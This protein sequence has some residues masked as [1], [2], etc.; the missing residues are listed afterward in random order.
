MSIILPDNKYKIILQGMHLVNISYIYFDK[1]RGRGLA[2]PCRFAPVQTLV[3]VSSNHIILP[4]NKYKI[5]LQGMHLV[6]LFYTRNWRTE[7]DS[8]PR[9]ENANSLAGCRLNHS[10][11]YPLNYNSTLDYFYVNEVL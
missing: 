11:I 3:I 1:S 5:I 2:T 9:G 7:G 6:I 10:A 8:N 4:D